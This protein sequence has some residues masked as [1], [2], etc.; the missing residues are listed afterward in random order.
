MSNKN[1]Q[2]DELIHRMD[3]QLRRYNAVIGNLIDSVDDINGNTSFNKDWKISKSKK[4]F[5]DDMNQAL[6]L[7]S[8]FNDKAEKL[9]KQLK[10]FA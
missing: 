6:D 4:D 10:Q 8:H 1:N 9:V 5:N 3:M 2:S 7:F